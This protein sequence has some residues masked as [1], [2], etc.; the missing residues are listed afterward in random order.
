M[1]LTRIC[2]KRK[3]LHHSR[4]IQCDCGAFTRWIQETDL[5]AKDGE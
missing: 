1:K 2:T 3:L 5:K 4:R